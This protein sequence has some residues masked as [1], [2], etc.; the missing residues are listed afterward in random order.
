MGTWSDIDPSLVEDGAGIGPAFPLDLLPQPWRTW[1]TDTARAAG[2]PVDYVVQSVLAAVAGVCGA[3][4]VVR[5]ARPWS[6]PLVLWQ[7]LVGRRSSGKS[8][9]LAPVRGLLAQAKQN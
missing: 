6:E 3:G 1:I 5:V 8:P 4:A 2:A 9:A 7:A